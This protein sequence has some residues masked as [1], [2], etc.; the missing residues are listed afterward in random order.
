MTVQIL[1]EGAETFS[2]SPL[3]IKNP[4]DYFHIHTYGGLTPFFRGLAEGKLL[5]TCCPNPACTEH[6]IWLPPRVHCPD[7][8]TPMAWQEVAPR[9]VLYTH[10]TVL[11]PGS[12]F[13][14]STPCPLVSVE[15]E[16]VCTK[17]MSYLKEGKPEIGM[18]LE[19]VFNT[20]KPTYT[21]LDLAWI[22]AKK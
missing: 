15:I 8:Y 16:G 17:L 13:R 18:P 21:I 14:L 12:S 11:Y 4:K 20:A 19:A 3:V 7:C 10:T 6:R 5:G 1:K 2:L 9:G 22:P